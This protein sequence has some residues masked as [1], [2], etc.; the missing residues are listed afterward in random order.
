[1]STKIEFEAIDIDVKV[2]VHIAEEDDRAYVTFEFWGDIPIEDI[3]KIVDLH[4][5]TKNQEFGTEDIWKI[6]I[7]HVSRRRY[8]N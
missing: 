3:K 5:I 2:E 4:K 7:E 1:M 8:K 6:T